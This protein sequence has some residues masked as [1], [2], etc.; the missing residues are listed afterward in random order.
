MINLLSNCYNFSKVFYGG[1]LHAHQSVK[2]AWNH[3]VET[4]K[5]VERNDFKMMDMSLA[6]SAPEVTQKIF[7][8]FFKMSG[9]LTVLRF[10]YKNLDPNFLEDASAKGPV[11]LL[12]EIVSWRQLPLVLI[13][14][15]IV[16]VHNRVAHHFWEAPLKRSF[17]KLF[18]PSHKDNAIL[19]LKRRSDGTAT[20]RVSSLQL[21]TFERLSEEYALIKN[22]VT[23]LEECNRAIEDTVSS[24]KKIQALF[25][26]AH[27]CQGPFLSLVG[28]EAIHGADL[29]KLKFDLLSDDAPIVFDAC[30]AGFDLGHKL[31]VAEWAQWAAGPKRAVYAA[32]TTFQGGVQILDLSKKT[33]KMLKG[34]EDVT[35]KPDYR[36]VCRKYRQYKWHSAMK[37]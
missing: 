28:S 16:T 6:A 23:S 8:N 31:N 29:K 18:K 17:D 7:S 9:A 5:V 33:F 25:M 32:K 13:V 11:H 30:Y 22:E 21:K 37:K 36:A 4:A 19:V 34:E 10:L 26:I 20:D 27:G 3:F 24:G 35:F 12:S 15:V 1:Y 2:S 14:A